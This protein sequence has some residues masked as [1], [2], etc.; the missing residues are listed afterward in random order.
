MLSLIIWVYLYD[1]QDKKKKILII[2]KIAAWFKLFFYKDISCKAKN[3]TMFMVLFILID[4]KKGNKLAIFFVAFW[5]KRIE[6]LK[7]LLALPDHVFRGFVFPCRVLTLCIIN[8]YLQRSANQQIFSQKNYLPKI[9]HLR[10]EFST[11]SHRKQDQY[12]A[13]T[14]V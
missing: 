10:C 8:I 12:Q 13:L 1:C 9:S 4:Y 5:S 6:F 3:N 7:H 14:I 2:S 11:L